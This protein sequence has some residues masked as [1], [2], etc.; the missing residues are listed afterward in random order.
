MDILKGSGGTRDAWLNNG[1]GWISSPQW[2]PSED[3]TDGGGVDKGLRL[4]DLNGDGLVDILQ[5]YRNSST[6]SQSAFINNGSGWTRNDF[7]IS[8]VPFT[9][10]GKNVGR[11][12]A[13][14]NGDGFGD[15]M[16]SHDD[17]SVQT[18]KTIILLKNNIFILEIL[19]D[20]KNKTHFNTSHPY[21]QPPLALRKAR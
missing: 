9:Q 6:T 20:R 7:W 19:P 10:D 1:S 8:P 18:K 2:V 13:D 3:F 17:G 21:L 4:F 16:I 14:V 11:R 15:I 12:I 5:D